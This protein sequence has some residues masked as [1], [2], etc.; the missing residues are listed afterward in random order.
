MT[1]ARNP[2]RDSAPA[3]A[4]GR[5]RVPRPLVHATIRRSPSRRA[6]P[7]FRASPWSQPKITPGAAGTVANNLASLRTGRVEV[8]GIVGDDGFGYELARALDA[9]GIAHR[10]AA[11]T[12]PRFPT[13]TYTKLLNAADRRGGS[14][15]R[16]FRLHASRFPTSSTASWLP[17][18]S[19]PP[20]DFDVILVSDQA[21]TSAGGV[22]TPRLARSHPDAPRCVAR[23]P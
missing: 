19:A 22:V 18:S 21:E 2:G 13:F 9:R 16:R 10:P 12:P 15:A 7:A 11:A 4:G 5:R 8:L 23:T 14:P 17:A 20:P 1:T 3:R 6:K